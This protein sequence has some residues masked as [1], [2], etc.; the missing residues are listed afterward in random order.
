MLYKGRRHYD[1]WHN[2]NYLKGIESHTLIN[3]ILL[4][5]DIEDTKGKQLLNK[6]DG[7]ISF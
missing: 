5:K 7:V 1:V 6:I 4:E 3:E 2:P